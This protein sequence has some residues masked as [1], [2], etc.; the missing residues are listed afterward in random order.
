MAQRPIFLPNLEDGT[1]VNEVSIEFHWYPGMSI[2]Q[3]RKSIASLHDAAYH[4]GIYPVLEISTKSALE[5]GRRLSAFNLCLELDDNQK[6]SVEAAYQG[7]KVFMKGG[8]YRDFY[9]LNGREIKTDERLRNS[10]DLTA[11]DFN[12][13]SWPLEPKTAFY[14]W[15]YINA[16]HQNPN[17]SDQLLEYMGFSDIEFNPHKSIN[18]QA[19]AA[20]LFVAL[21]KYNTLEYALSGQTTFI[22]AIAGKATSICFVQMKL[23]S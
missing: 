22:K 21:Y 23:L 14:D 13:T 18:C 16:L 10:G 8:P 12:G 6:V 3:K 20:A 7:S 15:L 11:F 17:L 2:Q 1:L 9:G 19:R 5:I 4:K